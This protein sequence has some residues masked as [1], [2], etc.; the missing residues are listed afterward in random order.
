MFPVIVSVCVYWFVQEVGGCYIVFGW[1]I[2]RNVLHNNLS[3]AWSY[4]DSSSTPSQVSA[5][6]EKC[7]RSRFYNSPRSEVV[8]SVDRISACRFTILC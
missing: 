2:L 4:Q 3:T 6:T 5:F 1:F 8:W 7:R